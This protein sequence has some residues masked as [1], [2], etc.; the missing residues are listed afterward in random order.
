MN[1]PKPV[2][3]GTF[4]LAMGLLYLEIFSTRLLAFVIGPH[5]VYYTIA[6]AMLGLSAAAVYVSISKEVDARKSYLLTGISCLLASISILALFAFATYLKKQI[7]IHEIETLKLG[8]F[9]SMIAYIVD[10]GFTSSLLVGIAMSIPYLF[11]G[12]ALSFIFRTTCKEDIHRLYFIDLLGA[13]LGC[14]AAVIL[15]ELFDFKIPLLV[16]LILPLISAVFF[17]SYSSKNYLK[18]TIVIGILSCILLATPLAEKHLEPKPNLNKLARMYQY[19]IYDSAEELW[20]TWTSYGRIA[21]IK[22]TRIKRNREAIDYYIMAHGNGEGHAHVPQ[23]KKKGARSDTK[24]A[25]AGCDPKRVLV[26]FAGVGND[27]V[28]FDRL[29]NGAADITGVELIPQVINWPKE[30]IPKIKEFIE[31]KNMHL[32][33]AEGREFL[34]RDKT[35]YDCI[36]ASWSGASTSYYTGAAAAASNYLYTTEGL[37]AMMDRLN[38]GGQ[39]TLLD[40]NKVRLSHSIKKYFK[41]R[42]INDISNKI[43]LVNSKNALQKN[44]W[45]KPGDNTILLVKPSGFNESDIKKINKIKAIV[46]SFKSSHKFAKQHKRII[47]NDDADSYIEKWALRDGVDLSG[48]SDNKPLTN[49]LFP[50]NAYFTSK[51]WHGKVKDNQWKIKLSRAKALI[52][53]VVISVMIIFLPLFLSK[54][55]ISWSRTTRNSLVYF[56]IIGSAFMLMEVGIIIKL[57]LL[58]GHPGY[59]LG[60]VLSSIVFFTGLGSLFSD[61]AIKNRLFKLSTTAFLSGFFILLA[62]FLCDYANYNLLGYS[63][64][65]KIIVAFLIPAL[66]AFFMGHLFPQGLNRISDEGASL[67]PWAIAINGATGTIAS[68]LSLFIMEIAGVNFLIIAAALLYFC[69]GIFSRKTIFN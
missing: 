64:Y 69:L 36:L 11:F 50:T 12:A 67:I 63:R 60:I 25:I 45:K 1:T 31:K 44:D 38:T 57:R 27:M 40:G 4:F 53:F 43:V 28:Q 9:E 19:K 47:E 22:R 34:S 7:N 6:I 41:D 23:L 8:G 24:L 29:T 39:L 18:A 21:A 46:Y 30:N 48:A 66:P 14:A 33:N 42:G 65:F 26:I 2:Y 68:G 37:G 59:T 10:S 17:F 62:F 55:K 35:K 20:R 32:I 13:C 51:F 3:I 56:S 5:Y 54:S 58:I 16:A 15:L 49:N 61:F 52:C